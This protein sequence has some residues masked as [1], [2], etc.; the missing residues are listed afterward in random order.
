LII[1]LLSVN[2]DEFSMLSG[3]QFMYLWNP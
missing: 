1:N 2:A 3:T